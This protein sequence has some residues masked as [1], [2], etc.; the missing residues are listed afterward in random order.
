MKNE[1]I[2]LTFF[3][4]TLLLTL[5]Y[6]ISGL[7]TTI[8]I[9]NNDGPNEGLND[10]TP[11]TPIDGNYGTTLGEQR[12]IV[13]Q[14]AANFLETIINNNVE[15][16]IEASF[17]PLTP[18]FI[19]MAS[20]LSWELENSPN[21]TLPFHSTYY[22]QALANHFYG[23]DRQPQTNDMAIQLNSNYANNLCDQ[24]G[25]L[26]DP[27]LGLNNKTTLNC[28]QHVLGTVLHEMVHGLGFYE[29]LNKSS[30]A[31]NLNDPDIYSTQLEDHSNMLLW[32]N[33]SNAQRLSSLSHNNL[34]WIGL[35]AAV[36]SLFLQSQG[37]ITTGHWPAGHISMY[38]SNEDNQS[39]AGSHFAKF[40]Y[41]NEIMEHTQDLEDP[42]NTIG[43]AKQV[44]QD[45]GW[46]V[47]FNGDEPLISE[48][49][50]AEIFT[51]SSYQTA[52]SIFDNDN[53]LHYEKFYNWSSSGGSPHLV[54]GFSANSSDQLIVANSD[55]LISGVTNG[56]SDSSDTLRQLIITPQANAIGIT[57][58]TIEALD[59]DGNS[60]LMS[61]DL[62]VNPSNTPP[63]VSIINPSNGHT[64]LT[65]TQTFTANANDI[66]DGYLS[67]IDW[68]VRPAGGNWQYDYGVSGTWTKNLAD[69][70]YD[71]SACV[72]DSNNATT[73]DQISVG[74][75]AAADA[76]SDGI[77]NADEILQGTDPHN[78]DSD[79]D[80]LLDGDDPDPLTPTNDT[81]TVP[82]MGGLSFLGLCL[83]M[84]SLGTIRLRKKVN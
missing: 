40:L 45:I 26:A 15:I 1:R 82:V 48:I 73:C 65:A 69:S 36:Q 77:S 59:A 31:W 49:K 57:T 83:S 60:D 3:W 28:Q 56:L 24:L 5:L 22:P 19:G 16:K 79:N 67:T 50:D 84:L 53:A 42:K 72:T 29:T 27:Y 68:G 46:P 38:T 58:I 63:V 32:P 55:I 33:M 51:N 2:S 64:F 10:P 4:I 34:H 30:G 7:T 17:D 47:F 6:P 76:D 80:G 78:N 75:S 20:M 35:N 62:I 74:V 18:G 70:S 39:S 23:Y 25:Y 12:M 61:F 21:N 11:M 43:L 14:F 54:M 44:L 52:F 71:I 41:P 66:E 13:L 37:P 9:I 8:T 81:L